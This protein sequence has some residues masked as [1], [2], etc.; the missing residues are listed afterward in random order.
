[1]STPDWDRRAGI[2]AGAFALVAAIAGKTAL[3]QS[4]LAVGNIRVDFAALR[5]SAGDPT[6]TW[7]EQ[8]LPPSS[9]RRCPVMAR[10]KAARWSCG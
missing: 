6:A 4:G 10:R 9:P 8:E 2:A 1:M 3:A 7:V 5:A